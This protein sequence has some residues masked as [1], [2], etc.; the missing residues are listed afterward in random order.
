MGQNPRHIPVNLGEPTKEGVFFP[1][2]N[3]S[4][5]ALYSYTLDYSH[6]FGIDP[7]CN[8]AWLR[9]YCFW[10]FT[11]IHAPRG[12]AWPSYP[13]TYTVS[14]EPCSFC[15]V[16]T[17]DA[18]P[19]ALFPPLWHDIANWQSFGNRESCPSSTLSPI[20]AGLREA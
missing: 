1:A 16:Q 3:S 11:S 9:G 18:W 7:V 20:F 10:V 19:S 15:V 6:D 12:G 5:S 4:F 17:R 13:L 8:W 14:A 2:H